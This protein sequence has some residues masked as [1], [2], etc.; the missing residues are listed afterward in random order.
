MLKIL[1]TEI[2]VKAI[3]SPY[4]SLE[5]C[6]DSLCGSDCFETEVVHFR[7]FCNSVTKEEVLLGWTNEVGYTLGLPLDIFDK[8]QDQIYQLTSKLKEAAEDYTKIKNEV[9]RLE[10][11]VNNASIWERCK[12]LF[13]GIFQGAKC[14]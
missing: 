13:Q 7:R 6:K 1:I 9:L 4:S 11:Q 2:K 12:Y 3:D 14:L 5:I 10:D 8:Q